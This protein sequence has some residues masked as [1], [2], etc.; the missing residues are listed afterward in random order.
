MTLP[1]STQASLT[2]LKRKLKYICIF[3][4]MYDYIP[5]WSFTLI[6]MI[7][8]HVFFNKIAMFML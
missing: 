8:I 6:L 7:Y 5:V 2:V 3:N 1:T 4:H